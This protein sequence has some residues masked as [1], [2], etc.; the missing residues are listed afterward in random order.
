MDESR[1]LE[2]LEAIPDGVILADRNGK[3]VYANTSALGCLDI[4]LDAIVGRDLKRFLSP[5]PL[6]EGKREAMLR[7]KEGRRPV[8]I[9]LSRLSNMD[10]MVFIDDITE[11]HRLQNEILKI[12]KLASL[13]G[14]TAGIAHEIRNPLAG[15]KTTVQALEGELGRHDTRRV[16]LERIVHE[17]NRL[18][19]LLQSFFDF[20]KPRNPEMRVCDVRDIV[21]NALV[22]VRSIAKQN[23]IDL[24][25]SYLASNSMVYTDPD[26]VSQVLV[27]IFINAIQ[28]VGH[29]GRVD[30]RIEDEG[31]SIIISVIDTG[32][33]IP[34]NIRSKIFDP[35]FTTRPDGMGLGLSISYRLMRMLRGDIGLETSD[36][37]TTFR[38]FVPKYTV[39]I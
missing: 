5:L 37:G 3:I 26:M 21:E 34:E 2:I 6:V 17:I 1:F 38:V 35:F 25:Q 13:G 9:I 11:I 23:H 18:N 33:G 32:H 16:Y 39:S 14:L 15:I 20:A 19:K 27:N 22:S 4:G 7:L 12:D 28:A 8:R 10:W 24:M 29:N 30:V 36:A 31:K